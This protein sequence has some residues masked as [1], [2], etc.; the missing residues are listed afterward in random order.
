MKPRGGSTGA[1]RWGARTHSVLGSPANAPLL[2]RLL[3]LPSAPSVPPRAFRPRQQGQNKELSHETSQL[4]P[5]GN[6]RGVSACPWAAGMGFSRCRPP[7]C[8]SLGHRPCW[9]RGA[10][11]LRAGTCRSQAARPGPVTEQRRW[12]L[13]RGPRLCR[14]TPL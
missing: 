10:W 1:P 3:H 5:L 13:L 11:Q 14:A 12:P 6:P 2:P 8:L 9:W 4:Q 7:P